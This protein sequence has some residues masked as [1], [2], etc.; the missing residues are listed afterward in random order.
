[1]ALGLVLLPVLVLA[2]FRT[3]TYFRET[4]Q[5]RVPPRTGA[6]VRSPV[7]EFRYQ[8]RGGRSGRPVLFIGGTMAPSDT[9]LPLMD[10]LCDQRLRCLAI[11]LPPFGYSDRP[12]D[13]DYSRTQ[14][15]ARIASFIRALRLQGTVLV[16]HSFGAGPTVEAAMR[17]PEDVGTF[18]LLDGALGLGSAPPSGVVRAAVSV[19]PVRTALS[20]ATFANPWA[21]RASLRKFIENDDVVTDELVERFTAPTRLEGMAEATGR[22]AQTA[23]FASD[24][25]SRSAQPS[26][27]RQYQRA[28]LLIWGDKDIATPL[29]QG[30]ELA[31]LLPH[32]SLAVIPSVNHFPHLEA[33]HS[34]VAALRP[35]LLAPQ[36]SVENE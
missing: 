15:A 3:R 5:L 13:G 31:K 21:I 18:V 25:Q 10:E 35:F 14:Q 32:A 26:N 17:Y 34:V 16:G 7:G 6:F 12:P 30:E 28:V 1:V 19:S 9:F 27:Y 23:F 20:S 2:G 22:W 33:Q 4:E 11:D 36:G 29:G 24:S 8:E